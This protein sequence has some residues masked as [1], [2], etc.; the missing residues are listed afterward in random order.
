MAIALCGLASSVSAVEMYRWVDD[1]G[2]TNVSDVVPD[3]YRGSAQRI[4]P[5]KFELSEAR[6]K[7]AAI[8]AAAQMRMAS[9][10]G[11]SAPGAASRPS[12]GSPAKVGR[13]PPPAPGAAGNDC[14]ALNRQ[15][16]AAVACFSPCVQANGSVKAEC[17][18]RCPTL[19]DPSPR[20]GLPTI[21]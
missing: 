11:V 16:L 15:Y 17:Y 3:R 18:A 8:R 19:V 9:S 14:A 10:A 7:D 1:Q 13:S 6:R 21:Q 20:C 4:D 5:S 2:H 12:A